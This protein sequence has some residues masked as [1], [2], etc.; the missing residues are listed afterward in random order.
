VNGNSP[1]LEER[2]KVMRPQI[3]RLNADIICFQEVDRQEPEGEPPQL[4]ALERLL[5]MTDC[6]NFYIVPTFK[7]ENELFP[8]RNLVTISRF[9]IMETRQCNNTLIPSPIYRKITANP[10][11]DAK[12]IIWERPILYTKIKDR[13]T[14]VIHLINLHLKSRRPIEIRGQKVDRYTW[15]SGS[16]WAEAFFV[17]SM[18]R[19]GQALETRYLIDDIFEDDE[20]AK[21]IVCG[22]LN[23][24]PDEVPVEAICGRTENTGNVKLT[25]R[26]LFPCEK[27]IPEPSRYTYIHHGQKRLLDHMLVSLNMT[28]YYK[29]SEIHNETLH[30]ET[31]A[32][33]TD[34]KFPGSDH[35]PFIAEFE[36]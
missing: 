15:K 6:S 8:K 19:V 10:E 16:G 34:K 26:V 22:D 24:H 35:A 31:I 4:L 23:A 5:E 20:D 30:D 17:S 9:E 25:K 12:P 32:F 33:A 29:K 27:S 11:E 21:I 2:L 13:P 3:K 28:Q 18:K 1:S 14:F 7:N 36:I